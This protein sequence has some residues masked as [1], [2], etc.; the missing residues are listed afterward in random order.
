[1]SAL[2]LILALLAAFAAGV[3]TAGAVKTFLRKDLA[4]L[5]A[6]FDELEAKIRVVP[7]VRMS[8]PSEHGE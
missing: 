7:L 8:P 1:M 5:H 4:A 6:R 2:V 3:A